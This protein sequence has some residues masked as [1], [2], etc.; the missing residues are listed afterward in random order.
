MGGHQSKSSFEPEKYYGV[1]VEVGRYV[2][3]D[4]EACNDVAILVMAG[5]TKGGFRIFR[6][7]GCDIGSD[8]FCGT[9]QQYEARRVD[10]SNTYNIYFPGAS[11]AS[12]QMEIVW[13]DYVK[14]SLVSNPKRNQLW[15]YQ[16]SED[17]NEYLSDKKI[18][19][20]SMDKNSLNI[21][22]G[23]VE[24]Y[25]FEPSKVILTGSAIAS[26]NKSHISTGSL[27]PP[28]CS[29]SQAEQFGYQAFCKK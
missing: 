24:H 15:V 21:L 8:I 26:L 20:V 29:T 16:K 28:I 9:S 17:G 12:E 3:P 27:I 6:Y 23:I 4:E 19:P 25:G 5:P 1:W 18:P 22:Q 14:Y 2:D 10:D 7:C 11:K 13:T